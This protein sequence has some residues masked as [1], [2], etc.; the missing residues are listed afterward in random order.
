MV[1]QYQINSP[2]AEPVSETVAPD[3]VADMRN[4]KL[5]P[6]ALND[7]VAQLLSAPGRSRIA[8]QDG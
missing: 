8:V 5:N 2:L 4:R 6:E 1:S 7:H 3:E